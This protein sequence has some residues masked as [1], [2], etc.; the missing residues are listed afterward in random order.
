MFTPNF[1]LLAS[2]LQTE[3][4]TVTALGGRKQNRAL[5]YSS[6]AVKGDELSRTNTISPINALQGKVAGL[7]ISTNGSSGVTSSPVITLRGAKSLTKNNSPIFVIDGIVMQNDEQGFNASGTGDHYGNQLKNLNP[8]DYESITVLKGAAATALYGS[9][10][11]N[12]AIV[13]TTKGGKARK[14]IGVEVKY[15]HEWQDTYAAPVPLQNLYG[16]GR[17]TNGYEGDVIPGTLSTTA[18]GGYTAGSF[19]P[20][21][22]GQLMEQNYKW[23]N[24]TPE[25]FVAYPD[26]WRA[27]FQTGQYDDVSV[28]LTG[29]SEKATYRLSYA[30]TKLNGTMANNK[31]NRHSVNFR[32]NGKINDIFSVNFGFQYSNSDAYNG[33]TQ[34]IWQWDNGKNYGM[35]TTYFLNR[36]TDLEWYRDNYIVNRETWERISTNKQTSLNRL[37]TALNREVDDNFRHNEQTIIASLGLTAQFTDWLDA[38]VTASFNDFKKF[39]EEKNYGSGIGRSGTGNKYGIYGGSSGQ[40]NGNASLHGNGRFVDDNL[41]LDV[42]VG[43][44]MYGNTRATSFE[45]TTNG[46]LVVPGVWSFGNSVNPLTTSNVKNSYTPRNNMVV[47]VYGAINLSWK[48]QVFLEVTGRNDWVSSLLFPTWLPQGADNWS[49]FYPS[50]NASWVFSDTFNID[51]NILSFGKLRASWAQV[52]SGTGAYATS[53]GAGYYNVYSTGIQTPDGSSIIGASPNN[54][55]LP[56]YDLKPEIQQSMEFGADLRFL[57]SRIGV[58]VAYYKINTKNQ[59]LT[60]AAVAESGVSKRLINAGNIQ[61]Q[62]WELQLDVTPIRTRTVNW[63]IGFNWTRNRGK[64]KEL[65]DK[66]KQIQLWG[67][68]DASPSIY[69]FEGGTFGVFTGGNGYGTAP[70]VTYGEASQRMNGTTPQKYGDKYMLDYW[71]AVGSPNAIEVYGWTTGSDIPNYYAQRDDNG[72]LTHPY[73]V[74]G[75]VEPDFTFGL[76]TSVQVNL[77]NNNGSFDFFAQIDG[78]SGGM[79]T[80]PGLRYGMSTGTVKESLYGRDKE[81]GGIERVNWKGDLLYNGIELDG[82]FR[83][84]DLGG[85]NT[86]T[87]LKTG[88]EVDLGGMTY[89]EA[90]NEGHIKPML[91][92]AYYSY[93]FGWGCASDLFTT[94]ASYVALRELTIGYNF[95]EKW[96]KHVGMQSARLSFTARNLCY[97]YNG[98]YGKTNPE[99]ITSNNPLTPFDIGGVPFTR[100]FALTLDVRF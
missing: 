39:E 98:L 37:Q 41:E 29:G 91:A 62:G 56:N 53:N 75:S 93:A 73:D 52:G 97:I 2:V 65:H 99:S 14:G 68:Y 94:K 15:T 78:R 54:T 47:G 38:N 89:M 44:E 42:R 51:P 16:A 92:S 87:S 25:P 55:T 4:V 95:P 79:M 19:G 9:R 27:L 7:Q 71:G 64:I 50:V 1:H 80:N 96:I 57:N 82:V 61:N 63:N 20:R 34:G 90:V 21:L 76:N 86:M 67:G 10:G 46:G 48:D 13:I 85:E 58:D 74:L 69:A 43:A 45:K 22:D 23:P 3:A 35:L 30:Y 32:T 24:N 12:G 26:N 59:I 77:P 81:H 31:F 5:G 72:N 6:T 40:Y 18:N 17:P 83:P 36:N 8:N 88:Q 60:L 100:N 70:R 11:A 49:V 28:A 84:A 66:V 33:Q